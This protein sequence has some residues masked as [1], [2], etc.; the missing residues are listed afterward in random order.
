[1]PDRRAL[2][3]AAGAGMAAASAWPIGGAG[4]TP[5]APGAPEPAT[6][7]YPRHLPQQDRQVDYVVELMHLALRRSGTRY[8]TRQTRSEMVQA[9]ALLD[10]TSA[11]PGIDVFWTQTDIRRERTLLPV[12]IP[13]DR[14][15]GGWRLCLVQRDR[16]DLL[17][18]VRQLGDLAPLTAGQMPDWPDTAI[19]RANGLKVQVATHYQG[20]FSMLSQGRFDYFPRSIFEID[21]ELASV[22][23]L[24]LAIDDHVM[25]RYPTAFYLFVRPG[26]PRLA[27]DL[28]AGLESLVA[29]GTFERLSREQFGGLMRRHRTD[30]RRILTLRHPALPPAT[31][32]A[33]KALWWPTGGYSSAP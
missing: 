14:G 21:S 25:L 15:L 12:R 19:L 26:R 28:T 16:A 22:P 11:D 1:M 4:A 9:R 3:L 10:M 2:L 8:T 20:L 33:R 17:A 23:S 24:D 5:G 13:L 27:A 6:V 18:G 31:P 30:Q 32:L 7:N 29:D